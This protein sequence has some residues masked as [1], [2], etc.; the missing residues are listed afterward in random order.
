VGPESKKPTS[1]R[2]AASPARPATDVKKPVSPRAAASPRKPRQITAPSEASA[3]FDTDQTSISPTLS[4][5]IDAL[6]QRMQAVGLND[7]ALSLSKTGGGLSGLEQQKLFGKLLGLAVDSLERTHKEFD[8]KKTKEHVQI[9]ESSVDEGALIKK[10]NI[11]K[12]VDNVAK[13]AITLK[14]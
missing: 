2:A 7:A 4:T 13:E 9:N 12:S 11:R 3:S 6:I 5:D 14:G 8:A 10:F 1:P